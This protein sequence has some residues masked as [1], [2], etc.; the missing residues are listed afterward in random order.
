MRIYIS[1]PIAGRENG[2]REAFADA[3]ARL[4]A[5]GHEVVNPH[6]VSHEHGECQWGPH[7]AFLR[8][9]GKETG[10]DGDPHRYGCYLLTDLAALADVD[11]ILTLPDWRE[12]AGARVEVAFAE[13]CGIAVW[14][15]VR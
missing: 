7:A 8:C 3:A 12:S 5:E 9:F 6:E 1:G 14:H 11:V 15:A 10:R 4:Q 2:N 13:A